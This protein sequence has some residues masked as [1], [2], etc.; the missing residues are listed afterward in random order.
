MKHYD[1]EIS[2]FIDG[3]LEENLQKELFAHLAECTACRNVL[4][5]FLEIRNKSKKFFE[6]INL[7]QQDVV[8]SG[9]VQHEVNKKNYYIPLFYFFAAASIILGFL[10]LINQ[11][12]GSELKN[13]FEKLQTN[14]ADLQKD[15]KKIIEQKNVGGIK[16]K[17]TQTENRM[18]NNTAG[19]NKKKF[20][21]IEEKT[22]IKKPKIDTETKTQFND[23]VY[24]P[25][26]EPDDSDI[27]AIFASNNGSNKNKKLKNQ[28]IDKFR[29]EFK[30]FRYG[31][32][33]GTR[34]LLQ[35]LTPYLRDGKIRIDT[36]KV[37]DLFLRY[38]KDKYIFKS[39]DERKELD[40]VNQK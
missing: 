39:L 9:D 23:V 25:D 15:Y 38:G 16:V 3:E 37:R 1:F 31:D 10:F 34:D 36:A 22:G 32:N 24:K 33:L 35:R 14:Y 6:G 29:E 2:Q 27:Q 19:I 5:E 30:K 11:V 40:S 13:K 26:I 21:P 12:N 8:L 17:T 20:R 7:H 18:V 4:F 28:A